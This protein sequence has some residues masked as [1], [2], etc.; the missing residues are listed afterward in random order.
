MVIVYYILEVYFYLL[1]AYI[2]LGWIDSAR[3]SRIYN[4]IGKLTEPFLKIFSGWIVIGNID[5]TPMIGLTI[6]QIILNLLFQ[7]L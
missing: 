3:E 2:L 1:I 4:E 5:F 6:Y 7:K